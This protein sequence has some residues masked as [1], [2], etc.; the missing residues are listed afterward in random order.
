MD[1]LGLLIQQVEQRSG[2]LTDEVDATCV[3]D[4]VNVVPAD[5]LRPVLLL[6]NQIKCYLSHARNTTGYPEMRT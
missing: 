3:V 6:Y 2:L 1:S 4:V 5:A